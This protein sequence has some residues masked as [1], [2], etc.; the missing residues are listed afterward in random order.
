MASS[1]AESSTAERLSDQR[2]AELQA[3]LVSAE[4]EAAGLLL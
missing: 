2:E 3:A 4:Q 1:A